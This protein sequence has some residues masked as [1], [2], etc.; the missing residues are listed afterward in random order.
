[1]LGFRSDSKLPTANTCTN[2]LFVPLDHV[3]YEDFLW[4]MCYSIVHT[5]GFGN[6]TLLF[7]IIIIL[8]SC[9]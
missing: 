3:T 1:M 7:H 2:T 9:F 6:H 4:H 8:Y 5:T